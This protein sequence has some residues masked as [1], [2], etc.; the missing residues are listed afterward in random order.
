MYLGE[1]VKVR[2]LIY[3]KSP[4][5][6]KGIL[7]LSVAVEIFFRAIGYLFMES[8]VSLLFFNFLSSELQVRFRQWQI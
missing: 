3:R 1:Y 6:D 2:E 7:K 4:L 5:L 8:I